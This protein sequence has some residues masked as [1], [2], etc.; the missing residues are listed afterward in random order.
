MPAVSLTLTSA[1]VLGLLH[2]LE[3]SHAKAVL[4]SYFLNRRRTLLEAVV[5]ALV[6]T[7]AH[8]LTIFV[9]GGMG[10]L[11][12]PLF[13]QETV[14]VWGER[15]GAVL[16]IGI[17]LWMFWNER[18]AHFHANEDRDEHGCQGHFFHHH[19]FHHHHRSPSSLREVFLIGFCS[20]A[21]P[22]MSGLAVLAMAWTTHSPA[23]GLSM[24]TVFSLGLGMVVLILCVTMQQAAKLMDLYWTQAQRWSRYLPVVSSMLIFGMGLYL[25]F[26]HRA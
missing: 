23:L 7:L 3:P 25:L 9:L 15:A 11:L 5:F 4:A 8:T 2:S 16:M 17:G 13:S 26:F 1:F 12:G 18:K 19:D 21:I 6:V 20:G 10:F 14:E 24:V 22:C